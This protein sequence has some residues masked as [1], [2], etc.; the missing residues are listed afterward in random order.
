MLKLKDLLYAMNWCNDL[1]QFNRTKVMDSYLYLH[2]FQIW[3]VF[4]S[5]FLRLKNY[6]DETNNPV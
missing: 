5:D 2:M 1:K 6:F 3:F 4:L